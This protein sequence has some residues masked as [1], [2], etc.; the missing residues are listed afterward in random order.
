MSRFLLL[1]VALALAV[2]LVSR[3]SYRRLLATRWPWASLLV[4]GLVLQVVVDRIDPPAR[5]V[6]QIGWG[7]LVA[8]YVLVLGFA[9]RNTLKRGMATVAIGIAANFLAI[10]V[11]QG[12]P[13]D[14]PPD[15]QD[16]GEPKIEASIKHHP[17]TSDDG[18]L[19]LTD[20][21]VLRSLDTVISFGDLIVAFGIIDV[22]FH[23]SR[24]RGRRAARARRTPAV[25]ERAEDQPVRDE[26]LVD[27]EHAP[28]PGDE[29]LELDLTDDEP[30]PPSP[31]VAGVIEE[32]A[33]LRRAARRRH[34]S[35]RSSRRE[36]RRERAPSDAG[37]IDTSIDAPID[38][39][40][41]R[42]E[43][44]SVIHISGAGIQG[45]EREAGL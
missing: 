21:I 2:P 11:N 32:L 41:E 44:A 39:A 36:A 30:R 16:A 26:P 6:H 25:A 1:V 8:S 23:A 12:M 3:G 10:L 42:F 13:V 45:L 17:Q 7:M 14:V 20:I 24:A 31:V 38:D 9:L 28:A 22:A 18:L 27:G 4:A 5:G 37:P 19:F 34:P 29:W 15:W 40:L 43:H 33:A 35:A